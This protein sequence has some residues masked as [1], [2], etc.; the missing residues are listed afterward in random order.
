M[1]HPC[2]L[3]H[4]QKINKIKNM[5]VPSYLKKINFIMMK[6]M[7]LLLFVFLLFTNNKIAAVQNEYVKEKMRNYINELPFQM[8]DIK[9]PKFPDYKI[10]ITDFGAIGNGIFDNTES[11]KKAFEHCSAKGGGTII[12]P[13]GIWITGPIEFKSNINFYIE[14][15][16]LIIFSKNHSDYPLVK[17]PG[18]KRYIVANPIYGFNLSN[19]AITG[20]GIIDGSG[21]TWRPVKKDKTTER[22][23]KNLIASGGVLSKDGNMY[24][25]SKEAMEGENYLKTLD[26][27]KELTENDYLPARDFLRPNL[28]VFY[29]CKNIL[30]E[31]VTFQNSPKFAVNPQFCENLIIQNIKVLNEWWAQNGDGIDISSCLNVLIQNCTVN[32]GDDGICMKSSPRKSIIGASLK[33]VIIT[34]CIVYHGHGGFVIGSNTDGGMRN[35]FVKN[36]NFIGTDIGLRIKSSRGRGSL[37]DSVYIS[38]I[39]M[40]DIV[41][42]AILFDTYYESDNE[43]TDTTSKQVNEKTPV[44]EKF[45]ISNIFCNGASDAIKIVGLPEMPVR[46]IIFNDIVITSDK[47]FSSKDAQNISLNNVNFYTKDKVAFT[48]NNSADIKLNKI[49]VSDNTETF[50]QLLGNKSDK[51]ILSDIEL[52]NFKIPFRFSENASEKAIIVK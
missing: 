32:A 22:Q 11:F 18:S 15:G 17:L 46:Q 1:K 23:W 5:G 14:R 35:I 13:P 44:F 4:K 47:G 21:E 45:F 28:L 25:P 33:N 38:D 51:I 37:V 8:P 34:D 40:K 29:Q 50:I 30:L 42:E 20:D 10:K 43:R 36:C 6:I 12:V 19:I 16:A 48:I 9:P 49:K 39:Y 31:G 3:K 52:K 24:W 41:N 27:E 7:S 26:R 2:F